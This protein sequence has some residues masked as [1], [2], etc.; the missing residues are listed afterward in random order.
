MNKTPESGFDDVI[1]LN[2]L[3]TVARVL[4]GTAHDV[5]NAL[6]IIGGSAEL[7]EGQPGLAEPA[8]RALTRIRS[9]ATHPK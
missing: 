2:R 1:S 3:A 9:Q 7:L 5:N 6:Q 8:R 4:S